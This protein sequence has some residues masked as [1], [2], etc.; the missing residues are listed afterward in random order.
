MSTPRPEELHEVR[1]VVNGVA[2]DV[3]VELTRVA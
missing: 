2:H 1:L 3:A